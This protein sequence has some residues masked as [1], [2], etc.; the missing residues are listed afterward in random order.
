MLERDFGWSGIAVENNYFTSSI[1]HHL[2]SEG[3]LYIGTFKNDEIY[4]FG[5][6]EL[7]RKRKINA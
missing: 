6:N 1:R 3:F 4:L 5:G 2:E 7:R